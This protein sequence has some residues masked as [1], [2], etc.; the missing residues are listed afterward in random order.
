[1]G[2][3]GKADERDCPDETEEEECMIEGKD[4]NDE[5]GAEGMI[6]TLKEESTEPEEETEK[7]VGYDD[8]EEVGEDEGKDPDLNLAKTDEK[9]EEPRE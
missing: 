6:E 9:I 5:E 4:D 1:M 2:A 7:D 8:D 3:K